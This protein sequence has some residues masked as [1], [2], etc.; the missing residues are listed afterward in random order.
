VMALNK[1]AMHIDTLTQAANA[2]KNGNT[3]LANKYLNMLGAA[4]GNP[5]LA[6]FQAAQQVVGDEFSKALGGAAAGDREKAQGLFSP[7]MSPAQFLGVRGTVGELLGGQF[8]ALQKAYT[9][10]T[11]R[12]DFGTKLLPEAQAL[13]ANHLSARTPA[14][15][16]TPLGFP[17][18]SPVQ[19]LSRDSDRV[20]ILQDELNA[21]GISASDKAAIQ[22]EISKTQGASA[23]GLPFRTTMAGG[24]AAPVAKPTPP[25][26]NAQG[27]QLH[28]D[29]TGAFAYV[30]PDGKQFQELR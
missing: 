26:T 14:N 22:A 6:D 9:S 17:S 28:K 24:Q 23:A 12:N 8:D 30:S 16:P 27:W 10:S 15:A 4:T 1:V 11:G 25:L 29:R 21:P 2:L 7:N 13:L 18:V 3:P 20:R 19:Q 5:Q